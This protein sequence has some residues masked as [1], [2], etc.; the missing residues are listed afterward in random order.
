MAFNCGLGFKGLFS[1]PAGLMVLYVVVVVGGCR[2][3]TSIGRIGLENLALE[4]LA[5][6][7][8]LGQKQT[9]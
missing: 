1:C 2:A 5:S 8:A 4:L 7:S 6:M 3:A 9:F